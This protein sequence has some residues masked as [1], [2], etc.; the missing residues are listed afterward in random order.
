MK[1]N[2]KAYTSN[3]VLGMEKETIKGN[4]IVRHHF[5]SSTQEELDVKVAEILAELL[6]RELETIK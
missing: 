3:E 1:K 5:K 4:V 6:D 2:D